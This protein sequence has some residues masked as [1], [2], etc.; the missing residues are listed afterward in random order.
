MQSRENLFIKLGK[1]LVLILIVVAI[2]NNIFAENIFNT[3]IST[4]Y[5]SNILETESN[6]INSWY[7]KISLI[8]NYIFPKN[9]IELTILAEFSKYYSLKNDLYL[10]SN[11]K[12]SF[13]NKFDYAAGITYLKDNNDNTNSY[14]G[15]YNNFSLNLR[16]LKFSYRIEYDYF[17]EKY[18]YD[19]YVLY[20]LRTIFKLKTSSSDNYKKRERFKSF[21]DSFLSQKYEKDLSHNFSIEY[22]LKNFIITP[23]FT[24]NNSNIKYEKYQNIQLSL[25]YSAN[26]NSFNLDLAAVSGY[27]NYYKADRREYFLS[28]QCSIIYLLSEKYYIGLTFESDRDSSNKEGESYTKYISEIV[29]GINF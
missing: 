16:R 1:I 3:E 21:I 10:N 29:V 26:I 19:D 7:N 5:N 9:P 6:K 17:I 25:E 22:S 20:N 15:I 2:K 24:L 4:G 14:L 13:K 28:L 12:Y 11:F 8:D 27:L 18:Q 23:S